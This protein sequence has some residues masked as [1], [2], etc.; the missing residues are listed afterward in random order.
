MS[1]KDSKELKV[2]WKGYVSLAVLVILFSGIFSSSDNFLAAFDFSKLSGSF[3]EVVEGVT[4]TGKGGSGAK[5]GFLT[6]LTLIPSVCFALGLINIVEYLGGMEAAA[7][8]FNPLL[9]P[10]LG[11][12]GIT[13]IAF[14]SSFTS[15]DVASVMT[16]DLYDEGLITDDE[17][18]IFVSYQYAASAVILNT[19]NLMSPLLAIAP[20]AIGPIILVQFFCK[21]VGANIVRIYLKFYNRKNKNLNEGVA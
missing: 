16:R 15:S 9:K 7:K 17:R 13:G 21:L 10:I 14:V 18:T 12:P 11:I 1:N 20:L 6:A 8:I 2:T 4:F 5:D 3:G 19:I